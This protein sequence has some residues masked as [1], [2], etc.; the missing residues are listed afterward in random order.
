MNQLFLFTP[1]T[2]LGLT[3]LRQHSRPYLVGS[4]PNPPEFCACQ[5]M[6]LMP[7]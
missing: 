3:D 5:P 4:A 7:S 2:Y 6:G 1:V